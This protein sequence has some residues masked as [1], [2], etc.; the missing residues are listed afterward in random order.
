MMMIFFRQAEE[1]KALLKQQR[2]EELKRLKNL[3]K[4]EIANRMK[5]I[6]S[7]VKSKTAAGGGNK[8]A[9]D[10]D[11]D[12]DPLAWDLLDG[13]FDPDQHDKLM[14]KLL[15]GDVDQYYGNE[16]DDDDD[17]DDNFADEE[18]AKKAI[19]GDELDD[20]AE[21]NYDD[22]DDGD[23]K[24][25]GDDDQGWG[26]DEED[27]EDFGGSKR[28]SKSDRR[29]AKKEAKK[30]RK[31]RVDG[32][33]DEDDDD[34]EMDFEDVIAGGEIATRFKYRQVEA[35][36]FGMKPDHI[37]NLGNKELNYIAGM[38]LIAPY[39]ELTP[40]EK[41]TRKFITKRALKEGINI[42]KSKVELAKESLAA[43][44]HT[45]PSHVRSEEKQRKI[46]AA[47]SRLAAYGIT[48][49]SDPQ[50][51]NDEDDDE[52]TK[53][54]RS[55]KKEVNKRTQKL[56]IGKLQKES[57]GKHPKANKKNIPATGEENC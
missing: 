28:L 36:D 30:A 7:I 19:I 18:E 50:V 6:E 33:D 22:A 16:A 34:Y 11:G 52:V 9:V 5:K 1:K 10:G 49:S 46:D 45:T 42:K 29:K 43:Q 3:K 17:D 13:E 27:E 15:G 57:F 53:P 8:D 2:I 48:V 37:F 20:I 21:Y 54:R 55:G 23:Q 35:F 26:D 32:G 25:E 44:Q 41:S 12:L 51:G 56:L 47:S 40:Q 38:K 14:E 31:A 4:R 24:W 39:R